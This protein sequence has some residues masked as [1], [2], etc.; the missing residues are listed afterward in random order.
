MLTQSSKWDQ[1]IEHRGMSKETL[2]ALD[3]LDR[4][5]SLF[6]MWGGAW[7]YSGCALKTIRKGE[8]AAYEVPV[9]SVTTPVIRTLIARGRARCAA[10]G[11]D[12]VEYVPR[13][14]ADV[15]ESA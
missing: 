5:G 15:T 13:G 4:H 10:N 11:A 3:K 14:E 8:F 6:R 2:D 9:W 1:S 12:V 7:T